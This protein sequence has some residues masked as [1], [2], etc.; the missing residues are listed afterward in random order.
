MSS[1]LERYL[2]LVLIATMVWSAAS[3]LE[4]GRVTSEDFKRPSSG[5]FQRL[6]Y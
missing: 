5:L 6:C 4:L 3:R 2:F 1:R